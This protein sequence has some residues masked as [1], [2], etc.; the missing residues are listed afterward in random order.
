MH[1]N[2]LIA[3]QRI[4]V[5]V[6]VLLIPALETSTAAVICVGRT[7]ERGSRVHPE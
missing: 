5:C 2:T 1:Q 7:Q 3:G 4:V 6:N